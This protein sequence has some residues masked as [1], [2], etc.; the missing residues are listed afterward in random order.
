[1][2]AARSIRCVKRHT[3]N[4]GGDLLG[5]GNRLDQH[6]PVCGHSRLVNLDGPDL[7]PFDA[8]IVG[9]VERK[10]AIVAAQFG[11]PVGQHLGH[12]QAS[13]IVRPVGFVKEQPGLNC[14]ESESDKSSISSQCRFSS[15]Y[16]VTVQK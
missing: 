10:I 13:E 12:H 2:Q 4:G 7:H 3:G 1:M 16:Q 6:I 5:L 15:S 9:D 14:T 8:V 11:H